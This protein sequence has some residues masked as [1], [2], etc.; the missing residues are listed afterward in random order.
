M[1]T[2]RKVYAY[3]K[4]SGADDEGEHQNCKSAAMSSLLLLVY[5]AEPSD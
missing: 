2:Q 1:V 3:N 4:F 5:L